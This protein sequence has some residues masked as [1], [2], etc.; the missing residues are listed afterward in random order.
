MVRRLPLVLACLLSLVVTTACSAPE[1]PEP[2]P[3]AEQV[4]DALETGEPLPGWD[5]AALLGPEGPLGGLADVPH[6]VDVVSVGPVQESQDGPNTAQVVLE[7]S[8]QVGQEQTWDY[9]RPVQLELIEASE[10][11]PARWTSTPDA[12]WLGE[13]VGPKGDLSVRTTPAQRG[14]ITDADGTPIVTARPVLRLGLDKT[15]LEGGTE[16]QIRDAAAEVAE[17]VGVDPTSFGDQAVAAGPSAFVEGY[18][19]RE[20]DPGVDLD[21]LT[22]TTAGLAVPAE[23]PLGP[24]RSWAA[25]ILGRSGPATAEIVEDSDGQIQAGDTVGLSGLQRSLDPALRGQR[26]VS[27]GQTVEGGPEGTL[28]EVAPKPGGPVRLSLVTAQQ[29]RAEL[30]LEAETE[31]AAALVAL[32]PSDGHVLAAASSLGADGANVAMTAQVPPGSTFKMVTALALLR[33][34]L[35]PDSP[36]QCPATITVDGFEIGNFPD[37]PSGSTG[38]IPLREAIAQSCNTAMVSSRDQIS[39]AALAQAATALGVEGPAPQTWEA[40][41]GS[42]PTD[43]SGTAYAASLFGQG[44]VLMSPL[45]VATTVASVQAGRTTAPVLVLGP[46]AVADAPEPSPARPLT[47]TEAAQLRELMAGVVTDG[48]AQGVLGDLPGAPVIA[49]TGSAEVGTGEGTSV[50]SWVVAAQG[51]LVVAVWVQGGGYGAQ[52]AGPI[53]RDFLLAQG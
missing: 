29:N 13:G 35:T 15:R 18:S 47:E 4:A 28:F 39:P 41:L 36:V 21:A 32:R 45:A 23:L 52:T 17:V 33:A 40:F 22:Q 20:T 43:G 7:W 27:V 1:P 31:R 38:T 24:T 44:E 51:D 46:D 12:S 49:K 9:Q 26:G 8:W 42:V 48:G 34:G 19:V 5:D 6:T 10:D 37:Y 3:Y 14:D 16:A 2:D 11:D 30:A 25:A 50:D 53:V